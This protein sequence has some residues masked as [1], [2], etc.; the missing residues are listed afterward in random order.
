MVEFD[1][2]LLGDPRLFGLIAAH[3]FVDFA[4][5]SLL[6]VY[7]LAA[8]PLGSIPTTAGFLALSLLHFGRDLGPALSLGMHSLVGLVYLLDQNV[9]FSLMMAYSLVY[10]IPGRAA[11][12]ES[13]TSGGGHVSPSWLTDQKPLH[14][15]R[16]LCALGVD[17]A[18]CGALAGAERVGRR[19]RGGW[20][21][22]RACCA[23]PAARGP[24]PLLASDAGETRVRT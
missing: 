1:L 14:P 13:A 2:Q 24:P 12:L 20:A 18:V 6:A 5:P 16:P 22:T 15:S 8:V 17:K 11:F 7:A 19:L 10:H 3:G 23:A 9:A 4:S 21:A